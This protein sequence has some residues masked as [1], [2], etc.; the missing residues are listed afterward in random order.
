M[1]SVYLEH[2][3]KLQP[4]TWNTNIGIFAKCSRFLVPQLGFCERPREIVAQTQHFQVGKL[5]GNICCRICSLQFYCCQTSLV[6]MGTTGNTQR[7]SSPTSQSTV[8][9]RKQLGKFISNQTCWCGT[10]MQFCQQESSHRL[11]CRLLSPAASFATKRP[12]ENL[13]YN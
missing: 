8:S 5:A 9:S 10:S 6:K 12:R 1:L 7:Y 13:R 2:M 11:S 4:G 3:L